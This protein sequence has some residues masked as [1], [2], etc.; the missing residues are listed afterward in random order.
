MAYD[1]DTR[2]EALIDVPEMDIVNIFLSQVK[3]EKQ[4]LMMFQA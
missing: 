2:L 4:D 1:Y 3:H